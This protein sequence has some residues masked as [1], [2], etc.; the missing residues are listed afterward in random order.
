MRSQES[1]EQIVRLLDEAPSLQ[2]Y[3]FNTGIEIDFEP[4]KSFWVDGRFICETAGLKENS[5]LFI[6]E[7]S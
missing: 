1:A 4:K 7:D 3:L 5:T 2:V 6:L